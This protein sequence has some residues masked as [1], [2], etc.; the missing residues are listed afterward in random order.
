MDGQQCRAH[1]PVQEWQIRPQ[2]NKTPTSDPAKAPT[3][4]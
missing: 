2:T 3:K 4:H 1:D